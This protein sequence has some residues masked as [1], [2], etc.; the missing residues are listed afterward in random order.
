MI[1]PTPTTWLLR[2]G[3]VI[4]PATAT[5][6]V[7]DLEVTVGGP[8]AGVRRFR[9]SPIPPGTVVTELAGKVV[10]PAFVEIHAHLREPGG[11]VSETIASGLA[12]ARAGGYGTVLVMANTTP[13]NDEPSV[14]RRML[15]AA[16]AAAT[17]V[18]MLPVSAA[19]KGLAGREPAA[20]R[21][22]VEA[23]CVAISDDGKP[24]HDRR[25]LREVLAAARDLG[26]AY[27]SHAECPQLFHGPIHDGEAARRLGVQ[28]IPTTCESD[29]VQAEI[30]LA[31]EMGARIH[32]C[33][34]STTAS[35]A[36]LRAARERGVRCSA[37]ATPHHLLLTDDEFLRRGPDTSLKMNPPLRPAADRDA[38]REA[39]LAGIVEAVGTDHAPHAPHLKA[40]GLADAPFGA[41]GM[42][43]AFAVLH[44]SL[45]LRAGWPLPVLVE[46]MTLGP[47]RV[48][49]ISGGRLFE[50]A[51]ALTVIDPNARF[52]V[53]AENF[54]SK[55]RNCPFEGW[56]GQ[57]RVVGTLLGGSWTS[58]TAPG[59][60]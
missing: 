33:H 15:A 37:E 59:G 56:T 52:E 46:R 27:L 30:A 13:A 12:A 38:L 20:W 22:Q 5:D 3:R 8:S 53:R 54:R 32:I 50:G 42:E 39:T 25:I 36:A 6:D 47:A 48:A 23:G 21:E 26:V 19:T 58:S 16:E 9:G 4:D 10:V 41:I 18:R 57:G 51:A 2:G 55:S 35:I 11:E 40:R 31:E 17:G 14:T 49:G 24:V 44:E 60:V 7:M 1:D 29:C 45:V 34:V 28:G 43:S